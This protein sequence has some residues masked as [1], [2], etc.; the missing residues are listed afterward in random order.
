MA[1]KPSSKP[2]WATT[3]DKTEP[4]G[5]KKA[6]G[7]L[8]LEKPAYQF[9]NWLFNTINEFIDYLS[10]N[11]QYNIIVGGD[12][13]ERDYATM[14]AYIADSPAAGDRILIKADEVLTATLII[15]ADIEVTQLKGNKFTLATNF[16]P[17]IQL[18]NNVKIKG[19]LRIENSDTGTIAKGL[20]FNGDSSH[21]DNLIIE[22]KS[23][24]TITDAFYIEAT[25]SRNQ[26][27]GESINSGAGAITNPFTDNSGVVTNNVAIRN[28]TRVIKRDIHYHNGTEAPLLYVLATGAADAYIV[29]FTPAIKAYFV[30]LELNFKIGA[31]DT[32]TGAST[33]NVNSLG[34]KNIK[35]QDGTDPKAGTLRDGEIVRVRYDGTNFILLERPDRR[36]EYVV[37]TGSAD[38]YAVAPAPAYTAYFAGMQVI[39][40]A[41]N[42]NTGAST[43]NVNSLGAKTIK[44]NFNADLVAGDILAG[45]AVE[46]VYDGTNFQFISTPTTSEQQLVK[47]WISFDGTGTIAIN[48]SFNVFGITDNGGV[49]DYTVTWDTD[50]ANT[51]YAYAFGAGVSDDRR[52][53]GASVKAVGSLRVVVRNEVG[54]LFDTSDIC[55]IALGDQ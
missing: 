17:I 38:A 32:N 30:S 14:A 8:K 54:T 52:Y 16:S 1:T 40:K 21:C 35:M 44:K 37:D 2:F 19:E 43:L 46:V 25:K 4:S 26:I 13:D 24:G 50:F 28:A 31:G 7:W 36:D 20:S 45:Q 18:G 42:T 12:S 55:V 9:F 49:G 41:D 53:C 3:G 23:T 6:T 11:A 33:L 39:F 29:T 47:A 15:P 5:S 22:N 48:D 10:G 27:Q 51:D 34:V